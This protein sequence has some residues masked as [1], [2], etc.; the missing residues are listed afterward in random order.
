ME[1]QPKGHD[2]MVQWG[3]SHRGRYR[4]RVFGALGDIDSDTDSA[5]T[6]PILVL[7]SM[8]VSAVYRMI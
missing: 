7:F 4:N 2:H 6:I 3:K 8:Q 5:P 1:A